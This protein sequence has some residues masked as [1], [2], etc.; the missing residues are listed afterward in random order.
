MFREGSITNCCR[1]GRQQQQD[2][3]T[4]TPQFSVLSTQNVGACATTCCTN[5]CCLHTVITS[6]KRERQQRPCANHEIHNLVTRMLRATEKSCG[7]RAVFKMAHWCRGF[8]LVVYRTQQRND[9][10]YIY[11]TIWYYIHL[12]FENESRISSSTIHTR[13]L[14][15]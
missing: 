2:T 7:S 11:S 15:T 13:P 14:L 12:P 5:A 9:L 3:H 4:H 10:Q 1:G 6:A 8:L